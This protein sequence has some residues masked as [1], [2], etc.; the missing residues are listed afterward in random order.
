M[1]FENMTKK[2]LA[3]HS[4]SHFLSQ[5]NIKKYCSG[6]HGKR[7]KAIVYLFFI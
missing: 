4:L 2:Y 3:R 7:Q 1:T 6:I 5:K